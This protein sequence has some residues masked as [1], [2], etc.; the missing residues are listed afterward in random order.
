MVPQRDKNNFEAEIR[1]LF[2]QADRSQKGLQFDILHD[3][4]ALHDNTYLNGDDP[5]LRG[6]EVESAAEGIILTTVAGCRMGR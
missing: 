2:F 6:D 1:E 4:S 5:L 3:G